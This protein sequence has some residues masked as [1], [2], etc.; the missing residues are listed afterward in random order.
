MKAPPSESF[1]QM[2]PAVKKRLMTGQGPLPASR[3]PTLRRAEIESSPSLSDSSDSW[4]TPPPALVKAHE[5]LRRQSTSLD[6]IKLEMDRPSGVSLDNT[7]SIPAL[8]KVPDVETLRTR[9]PKPS[10][11]RV[12]KRPATEVKLKTQTLPPVKARA[13]QKKTTDPQSALLW[14]E[15]VHQRPNWKQYYH[16]T[17]RVDGIDWPY[18]VS[19]RRCVTH[20][21]TPTDSLDLRHIPGDTLDKAIDTQDEKIDYL[22]DAKQR[23]RR[24]LEVRQQQVKTAV[25]KR[26]PRVEVFVKEKPVK[27]QQ[28]KL[29]RGSETHQG[30]LSDTRADSGSEDVKEFN[31]VLLG[32]LSRLH[33]DLRGSK[34]GSAEVAVDLERMTR[35]LDALHEELVVRGVM[36]RVQQNGDIEYEW[37]DEDELRLVSQKQERRMR[38]MNQSFEK[39]QGEFE[40]NFREV[41]Q[42]LEA[43]KDDNA[44]LREEIL[45]LKRIAQDAEILRVENRRIPELEKEIEHLKVT[46]DGRVADLHRE[47]SQLRSQAYDSL[48]EAAERSPED[49]VSQLAKQLGD[50][51][52][53]ILELEANNAGVASRPTLEQHRFE[54][55]AKDNVIASF[56]QDNVAQAERL[57]RFEGDVERLRAELDT[58]Q[59]Q[60]TELHQLIADAKQCIHNQNK[61]VG[62]LKVKLESKARKHKVLEESFVKLKAE[63]TRK[64][65][66]FQS[67]A[68]KTQKLGHHRDQY[69]N[70]TDR[71]TTEQDSLEL[72]HADAMKDLHQ[73]RV[74]RQDLERQ[75]S[76]YKKEL[77]DQTG[78]QLDS[79]GLLK[80]LR[81]K[82]QELIRLRTEVAR[83]TAE[84]GAGD[85][86]SVQQLQLEKRAL[87]ER[88]DSIRSDAGA[89]IHELKLALRTKDME[90]TMLREQ[91]EFKERAYQ[92]QLQGIPPPPA[93]PAAPA[94]RKKRRRPKTL[95]VSGSI[96]WQGH[97][98]AVV[99]NLCR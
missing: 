44:R 87:V 22:R 28:A 47:F 20:R 88:A 16:P 13:I 58:A 27:P 63:H 18:V 48:V 41:L 36:R 34:T 91:M 73:E 35:K 62:A 61:Q 11:L 57:V 97:P 2:P 45:D 64:V 42:A 96:D 50:A 89:Q 51:R 80:S 56:K 39:T 15:C 25:S 52:A 81:E 14:L 49:S 54:L 76:R 99:C 68:D 10:T 38:R 71:M 65:E 83:M 78:R 46:S 60:L 8:V 59:L 43:S 70:L 23:L 12:A 26:S 31:R 5:V 92:M 90:L 67:L 98:S 95:E 85:D 24:E 4:D 86:T 84:G 74:A 32:H 37:E 33:I 29:E 19:H 82:E 53:R 55:M 6:D 77:Q 75:V 17:R 30:S 21:C 7:P 3:P 9:P 94:R 72:A 66:L 40:R 69:K 93:P 1:R 79:G